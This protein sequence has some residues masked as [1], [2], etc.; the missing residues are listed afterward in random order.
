MAGSSDARANWPP[1]SYLVY[2]GSWGDPEIEKAMAF[3]LI[4]LHPGRDLSNITPELVSR[5]KKG[6]DGK[7]GGGDDIRV[8]SYVSI[9]EDEDVPAGPGDSAASSDGPVHFDAVKGLVREGKNYPTRY[10]DEMRLAFE[11]GSPFLKPLKLSDFPFSMPSLGGFFERSS[12]GFPR[13]SKGQDGIPDENGVWGSYYVNAGD[14]E[15]QKAIFDRMERL[16]SEYGVDGFFLDTLDTASPWGNYGWMQKDM[17]M[18]LGAIRKRFPKEIVIA[19]RGLFLL[20]KYA[21]IVRPAIDGLMFESFLTEWDWT[22][23]IGIE[24]PYL[25]SNVEIFNRYLVP[26]ASR[27]DG[28][29]IF[30]LDYLN[31]SQPDYL[32]Y[33]LDL[34]E[35]SE[36]YDCSYYISTPDLQSIKPPPSTGLPDRSSSGLPVL[37]KVSA[38]VD[39]RGALSVTLDLRK[40]PQNLIAGKDYIF[41]IRLRSDKD[42]ENEPF[43]LHRIPVSYG[44]LK[45]GSEG[46][47]DEYTVNYAGLQK[48]RSYTVS[49]RLIGRDGK[50]SAPAITTQID[51]RNTNI[52]PAVQ[53]L[54][55]EPDDGSVTLTWSPGEDAGKPRGYRIYYGSSPSSADASMTVNGTRA[56]VRGLKNG[57]KYYF[58]VRADSR[59]GGAGYAS[60]NVTAV[61]AKRTLPKP[62]SN[63]KAVFEG[64]RLS[65]SWDAAKD[66]DTAAFNVYCL[67]FR[68]GF[69]LASQMR[70]PVKVQKDV[71][72]KSFG[73]LKGASVYCVF[74]TSLSSGNVEGD[75]GEVQCVTAKKEPERR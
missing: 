69:P 68:P 5:L 8:I 33:L 44:S 67:P 43:F 32:Q 48:G 51:T 26:E 4:I 49:A 57:V 54:A 27:K 59:E 73:P 71:T 40:G 60:P 18:L 64:D 45:V 63:L 12:S 28:F 58:T 30:L 23:Q 24:S 61:P 50:V 72:T 75:P 22:R 53:D 52:P 56:A 41:D 13:L 15:W 11:P 39:D 46:G 42:P 70:L 34:E 17:A 19:N 14:L 66:E 47:C 20:E 65:L 1:R 2:Y 16:S 25:E 10:L 74:I 6:R 21:D 35:I 37:T 36:K 55:A 29:H 62:P 3:D 38:A 7:E 9:G 31:R